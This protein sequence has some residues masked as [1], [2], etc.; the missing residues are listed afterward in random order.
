MIGTTLRVSLLLCLVG[1]S[2]QGGTK[3]LQQGV[4]GPQAAKAGGRYNQFPPQGYQLGPSGYRNGYD[5]GIG[6]KAGKLGYGNGRYPS[7]IQQQGIGM[8]GPKPGYGTQPGVLPSAGAQPVYGNNGGLYMQQPGIGVRPPRPG[9]GGAAGVLPNVGVQPGYG[10]PSGLYPNNMQQQGIGVKSSKPGYGAQVGALPNVGAQLGFVNGA[11][12]YPSNLQQPGY[13]QVNHPQLGAGY[14]PKQS[15]TGAF[16]QPYLGALGSKASKAGTMQ[17][18]YPNG[19]QLGA[20]NYPNNLQQQGAFQQPYPNGLGTKPSKAGYALGAGG[21]PTNIQQQGAF[22]QPYLNGA[23]PQLYPNGMKSPFAAN[24]GPLGKSSKLGSLGK[25]PYKS[26]ALS[27]DGLGLGYDSKSLKTDGGA[28]PYGVQN[29]F[30]D[31]AAAKYAGVSQYAYDS[32]RSPVTGLEEEIS[33]N[34]QLEGTQSNR[35]GPTTPPT[36]PSSSSA[37]RQNGMKGP[38]APA[39]RFYGTGYQGCAGDC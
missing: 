36:S 3:P 1:H 9:Y 6:V 17:Q 2:L 39:Y 11:G 37:Q 21:Y 34:S 32:V 7:N 26:Q 25:L 31:P 12:R 24:R 38:E 8:K 30:P 20:G 15:K 22:Q 35:V 28:I 23:Y 14:G 27:T 10:N 18:L 5:A 29:G 19:Y 4:S 13:G 16:Q 33:Q